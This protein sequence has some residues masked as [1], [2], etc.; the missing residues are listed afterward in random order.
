[1]RNYVRGQNDLRT[2]DLDLNTAVRDAA[3]ILWHHIHKH[4][5]KFR[6]ELGEELPPV[7]GNRQQLEQ[8]VVNLVMNALLALPGRDCEVT[9]S[10]RF[11]SPSS[12]VV[13]TVRDEGAGMESEVL[14]K[15]TEPFFTTRI[16]EGGTGLGLYISSSIIR[17][18]GGVMDFSSAPG[19]GTT[20]TVSFPS[21]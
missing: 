3:G 10:T 19:K 17:D 12:R 13:L 1:M 9:V 5:G 21:A 6:L 2:V 11:D 4:T 8:V 18:H 15:L 16:N 20:V 7:R 14:K